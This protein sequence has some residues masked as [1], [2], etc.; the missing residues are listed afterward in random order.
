MKQSTE[1][2]PV[3]LLAVGPDCCTL[4]HAASQLSMRR[5]VLTS[6]A[7]NVAVGGSTGDK[8]MEAGPLILAS[9]GVCYLGDWA[10]FTSSRSG[11]ASHIVTG[12]LT[13]PEIK[14]RIKAGLVKLIDTAAQVSDT[15]T[16]V[17]I[18]IRYLVCCI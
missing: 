7:L 5:V 18:S 3:P 2:E 8:W 14:I 1:R 4:L 16:Y 10:K 9:G 15:E 6:P 12:S 11:T 13:Q 17:R